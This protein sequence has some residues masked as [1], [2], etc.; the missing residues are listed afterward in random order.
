MLSGGVQN[1][2]RKFD[3]QGAFEESMPSG[4]RKWRCDMGFGRGEL[5]CFV[6][7][8][9]FPYGA[10]CVTTEG[11]SN[12]AGWVWAECPAGYQ[13]MGCGMRNNYLQFDPKSGFEDLR[14]V[15][16]KCLGDMGFGPGRV[17][18]YARCCKING[19]PPKIEAP[20][21]PGPPGQADPDSIKCISSTRWEK[22]DQSECIGGDIQTITLD[23][24]DAA[25]IQQQVD[26]CARKCQAKSSCTGF[27]FP[28]SGSESKKC[29][30]KGG[31]D[32]IISDEMNARCESYSSTNDYDS[33]AKL[34]GPCKQAQADVS[35]I[36]APN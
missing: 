18:V 27:T 9:K 31:T 4:D 23:G 36:V 20:K 16:N 19:P 33:Y 21:P 22:K 7:G 2:I 1:L 30:L 34:S 5:N 14:P 11:S 35:G 29:K 24:K 32:S 26:T 17:S 25:T 15:G 6:R 28:A 10:H 12:N 3:R 13:V 8:C